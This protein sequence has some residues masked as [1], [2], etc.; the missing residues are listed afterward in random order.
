MAE[1]AR[2]P[3]P[4]RSLG[5]FQLRLVER[6]VMICFVGLVLITYTAFEMWGFGGGEFWFLMFILSALVF[7]PV[8]LGI[9]RGQ[10]DIFEP[11]FLVCAAYFL[12]FVWAPTHD[13][14]RGN[15]SPFGIDIVSSIW[16]GTMHA[17]VGV[18]A[19]LVGYYVNFGG[20]GSRNPMANTRSSFRATPENPVDV[21]RSSAAIKYAVGMSLGAI[22]CLGLTF[23]LTGWNWSRLLSFGQ[24]GDEVANIWLIEQNPFLNY[25]HSTMEWFL[26]AFLILLVFRRQPTPRSR[27]FLLLGFFAVFTIYTTLGFRYRVLLLMMAP[28]LYHYMAKRK[29]PG[30]IGIVV[31]SLVTVLM[32]SIIGGTR[33]ATRAGADLDRGDIAI[34]ETGSNFT[35]DLRIYPPFYR[36]LDVF[37]TDY[38]YLWGSS[39]MYVF[40]SPIPRVL[41]PG[42]PDAPVRSVLRVI[43]G[44]RA[45]QQGLAYPNLGEFYVNFGLAGE[46]MGMF[47]FGFLLRRAWMFVQRNANDPWALILYAMLLPFLVQVVS[48]GYFVQIA[49]EFAFI[50]G[51]ALIGRYFFGER[52]TVRRALRIGA[53]PRPFGLSA[54]IPS[55]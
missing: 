42:K 25:L 32:V 40:I 47:L 48:R 19:M 24:Y 33:G 34:G 20:E 5:T 1:S 43:A 36:M 7:F 44:E 51:P 13:W 26:P 8:I 31:A 35:Q 29:R 21:R 3:V 53:T 27:F 52:A 54:E 50:F 37:P 28:V 4:G 17:I 16:R 30:V 9:S 41:W 49:Q 55:R 14:V 18:A 12:Y 15:L 39:Y 38:D 10:M 46:I 22:A 11:I 6:W 2:A 23:R 45:V